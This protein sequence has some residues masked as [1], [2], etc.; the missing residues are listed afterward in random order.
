[1]NWLGVL[2]IF[3]A[4]YALEALMTYGFFKAGLMEAVADCERDRRRTVLIACLAWPIVLW[5]CVRTLVR[6]ARP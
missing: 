4:A 3:G 1:V 6:S 5:M 2:G